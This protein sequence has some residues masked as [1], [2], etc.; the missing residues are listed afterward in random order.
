[1]CEILNLYP[2][3][4]SWL[5]EL[6]SNGTEHIELC[7]MAYEMASKSPYPDIPTEDFLH[8]LTCHSGPQEDEYLCEYTWPELSDR[9]FEFI[10][11]NAFKVLQGD[12]SLVGP[13]PLEI[14]YLQHYTPEQRRRHSVKP[15]ITGL[16][17]VSGRNR[18]SWMEKFY[19]DIQYVDNLSFKL[20]ISILLKT[21]VKII[22]RDGVNSNK[23]YT[24]NPFV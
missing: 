14:R 15:G 2:D 20:D 6:L 8:V 3:L 1:M 9:L 16:A 4:A 13:R 22:M 24:V 19:L 17:Q 7:A 5:R 11:E 21:F 23:D 12:L 18:L 10:L